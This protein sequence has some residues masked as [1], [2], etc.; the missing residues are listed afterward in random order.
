[1]SGLITVPDVAKILKTSKQTVYKLIESDKLEGYRIGGVW[2]IDPASV[3]RY[4]QSVST[5]PTQPV[6]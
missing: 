5:R 4:L 2:R 3:I 1:M 6:A